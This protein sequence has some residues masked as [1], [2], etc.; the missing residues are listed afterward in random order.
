[1]LKLKSYY[2]IC[3]SVLLIPIIFVIIILKR[4]YKY[5]KSTILIVKDKF[6]VTKKGKFKWNFFIK[7][8]LQEYALKYN[9]SLKI[10]EYYPDDKKNRIFYNLKFLILFFTLKPEFIFFIID[11]SGP[12]RKYVNYYLFII[13]KYFSNTKFIAHS[14]D[15]VWKFNFERISLAR[16]IFNCCTSLPY[17]YIKDKKIIFP[18]VWHLIKKNQYSPIKKRNLNITYIGRCSGKYI[19][20]KKIL[21]FLEK[22]N[23]IVNKFGYDFNKF[24]T[25]NDLYKKLSESKIIINFPQTPKTKGLIY[26]HQIRARIME[27]IASGCLLF[28][29]K[30]KL[31][32]VYFEPGKHYIDYKNKYDLAKKLQYY[33]SNYNSK[34][35]KIAINAH[36]FLKKNF[37]SEI[38]WKRIFDNI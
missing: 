31:M 15:P 8:S 6:I 35:I 18:E 3:T 14:T 7:E 20:R 9:S 16:K 11:V 19:L 21:D 17:A 26:R 12:G 25:D 32:N 33:A 38:I 22:N 10:I 29:Q 28:D 37:S 1:M 27:S 36:T 23:I 5:K 34:G 13:L 4:S 2:E 30:N 24:I